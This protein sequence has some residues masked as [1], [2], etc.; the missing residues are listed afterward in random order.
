MAISTKRKN[1]SKSKSKMMSK[2]KTNSKS[3]S[4]KHLN[5]S[6]KNGIKTRKMRGGAGPDIKYDYQ[7]PNKLFLPAYSVENTESA[8]PKS[9]FKSLKNRFFGSSSKSK[10]PPSFNKTMTTNTNWIEGT[11]GYPQ[12]RSSPFSAEITTNYAPP[13]YQKQNP[14]PTPS[15]D[16]ILMQDLITGR[17][18]EERFERFKARMAQS[19]EE[20]EIRMAQNRQ[21]KINEI[22]EQMETQG[23]G[24]SST[25]ND[26]GFPKK[27]NNSGS[28]GSSGSSSNSSST[29]SD[30]SFGFPKNLNNPGSS[31][32]TN[33]DYGFGF[34]TNTTSN[35]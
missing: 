15:Y 14:N 35:S 25:N 27:L 21:K 4:R 24:F 6:R 31:S 12:L 26:Y 30:S 16:N 19:Q 28:S 2:F 22:N 7:S 9:L 11:D 23:F 17:G 34:P 5:K 8:R 3:R 33:S 10:S 18:K 1:S 20:S 13:I 32:N 29:N